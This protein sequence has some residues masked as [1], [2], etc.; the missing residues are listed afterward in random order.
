[1]VQVR[2][3]ILVLQYF[4]Y[5][6]LFVLNFKKS[7]DSHQSSWKK[8]T[9]STLYLKWTQVKS[10]LNK[11]N[12]TVSI[13]S[14]TSP[15]PFDLPFY[16][17]WLSGSLTVE[18]YFVASGHQDWGTDGKRHTCWKHVWGSD[19]VYPDFPRSD[20]KYGLGISYRNVYC[21][22]TNVLTY[23]RL[24]EQKYRF[25]GLIFADFPGCGLA[26]AI[27]DVNNNF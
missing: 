4:T 3:K 20:K 12:E 6:H 1:M 17:N 23:E 16:T 5:N 15:F 18:P 24:K 11:V 8:F 14:D 21:E 10:H 22:G 9:R 27:I 7:D 26:K 19:D 13:Y 25:V 2:G